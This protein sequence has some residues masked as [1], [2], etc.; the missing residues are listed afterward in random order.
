MEFGAQENGLEAL[1]R[2]E[3]DGFVISGGGVEHEF[4][5]DFPAV[6]VIAELR[7]ITSDMTFA[8]PKADSVLASIIDK[9]MAQFN[10]EI[11][12]IAREARVTYNRKALR[13]TSGE[14]D[15]LEKK[16]EAVVG[17][18]DEYLPFDLYQDGQYKGIGGEVLKRTGQ[19]HTQMS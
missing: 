11:Q 9:Y 19:S 8:V 18:A 14:L 2:G 6:T 3:V 17:V 7:A 13:L 5:I 4:M 1:V 15:W 10:S 16:G 12:E